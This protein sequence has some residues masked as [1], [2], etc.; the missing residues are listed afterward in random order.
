MVAAARR[1]SRSGAALPAAERVVERG[2]TA[3]PAT[4]APVATAPTTRPADTVPPV[5]VVTNPASTSVASSAITSPSP[6]ADAYMNQL[7]AQNAAATENALIEHVKKFVRT[8]LFHRVK[9]ISCD[10]DLDW[11]GNIQKWIF[12]KLKF[13]NDGAME[14]FWEK[15]KEQVRT[16]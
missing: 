6:A 7:R 16:A 11:G 14:Q 1:G 9:F 13:S 4:P 10:Q 2:R 15:H 3:V 5:S 12:W 8:H